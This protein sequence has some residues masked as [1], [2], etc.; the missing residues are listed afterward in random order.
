[1]PLNLTAVFVYPVRVAGVDLPPWH[2]GDLTQ[3]LINGAVLSHG[4][5]LAF[6][7]PTE[8]DVRRPEDDGAWV[9]STA[10]PLLLSSGAQ[11]DQGLVLR[12]SAERRTTTIVSETN[13]SR[14]RSRGGAASEEV[15][16]LCRIELLHPS[17]RAVIVET[18]DLM[19]VDSFAPPT[20]E[21]DF[22]PAPH[23]TRCLERLVA[24]VLAAIE[25]WLE[26][27][28]PSL[29]P[30]APALALTPPAWPAATEPSASA[31]R[32]ADALEAELRTQART[33]FLTP[34]LSD[35]QTAKLGRE[36]PGMLVLASSAGP[37]KP[38]D[39]IESVDGVLALPHALARARL[40]LAKVSLRVRQADGTTRVCNYP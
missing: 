34:G 12:A 5:R 6:W 7:G 4:D 32:P 40:G 15:R 29:T 18:H 20:P 19:L 22:D 10:L 35:A 2:P 3:R 1:M 37:L 36:V 24:Q 9:A 33:H 16:W 31:T 14:G 17:S 30:A 27:P 25:P 11:A 21:M 8:F 39:F 13:D 28:R 38:G 23:A 26:R